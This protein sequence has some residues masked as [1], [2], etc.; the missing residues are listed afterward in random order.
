MDLILVS[1]VDLLLQQTACMYAKF[2]IYDSGYE[3]LGALQ[4][5]TK[6]HGHDPDCLRKEWQ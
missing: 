3:F 6:L 2:V 5:V 4:L 1:A